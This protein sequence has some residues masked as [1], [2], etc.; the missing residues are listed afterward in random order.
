MARLVAARGD[1]KYVFSNQNRVRT[2]WAELRLKTHTLT[3]FSSH[4]KEVVDAKIV[5]S[6]RMVT[7]SKMSYG[8]VW[9]QLLVKTYTLTHSPHSY[10]IDGACDNCALTLHGHIFKD[11]LRD[12]LD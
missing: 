2:V 11:M 9:T 6:H 10:K 1:V 8:T 3:H 7:F 4:K 5:L 12:A